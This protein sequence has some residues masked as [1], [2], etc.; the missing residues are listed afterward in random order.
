MPD[1]TDIYKNE[2]AKYE[3]LI[4]RQPNLIK[5]IEEIRAVKGLDIIDL[6]AGT[7]RLTTLLAQ[8][9][10][11]IIALDASETMLQITENKLKKLGY[12]NFLTKVADNRKLPLEDRSADVV[13]AGWTIAYLANTDVQDWKQNI[14]QIISELQRVLRPDGTIIIFETMGTGTEV[15]DPPHVLK[16]YYRILVEEYGFNHKWLR[17]DYHFESINE[18]EELTRFFFGDAL[19]NK[20]RDEDLVCLPECAG[21]WWLQI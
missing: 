8:E 6:G 13:V 14:T 7:G 5:I 20:V 18:A 16:E 1:H 11:S 15:P 19:A 2:A 17:T 3:L 12:S 10:K 9:A 21:V 4:S